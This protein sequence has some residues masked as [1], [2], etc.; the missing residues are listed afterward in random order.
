MTQQPDS[1]D[2]SATTAALSPF[3]PESYSAGDSGSSNSQSSSSSG[4]ATNSTYFSAESAIERWPIL[5]N[6]RQA[7][8]SF[9][10][11]TSASTKPQ[12]EKLNA[13]ALKLWQ[14]YLAYAQAFPLLT[15]FLTALVVLSAGPVIV[16]ASVTG[17]SL[18]ILIGIAT[19]IVVIIQS[20]VIG[21]TGGILL[22]VLGAIVIFTV[23]AFILLVAGYS[24]FKV[25]RDIAVVLHG[26]HQQHVKKQQQFYQS[27]EGE[28]SNDGH[29]K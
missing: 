8:T 26:H 6:I 24:G 11:E 10:V 1:G 12:R 25:T 15:L 23:I 16:F 20:I 7:I 14:Q 19:T 18:A 3:V 28:Q 4:A 5:L 21:I 29:A 9:I 22:F 13:L 17:V 27:K 2:S